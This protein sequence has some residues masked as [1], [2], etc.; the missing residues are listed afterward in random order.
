MTLKTMNE[1]ITSDGC[2]CQE[3]SKKEV[4]KWIKKLNEVNNKHTLELCEFTA[5]GSDSKTNSNVVNWIKHFFNI[6]KED[7]K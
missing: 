7:L 5:H 2:N 6:T 4:I 3:L 1:I